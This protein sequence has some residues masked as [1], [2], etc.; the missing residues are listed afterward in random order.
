[1]MLH[2]PHGDHIEITTNELICTLV[3]RFDAEQSLF[4]LLALQIEVS[5]ALSINNQLRMAATLRDA[6]DMI[7]ERVMPCR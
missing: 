6:A 5:D 7:E 2:D 1:M 3:S 4:T